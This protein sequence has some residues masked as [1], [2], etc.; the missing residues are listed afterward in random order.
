MATTRVLTN[1]Q[2]S[3]LSRET[4]SL[5]FQ[6]LL[7]SLG[8]LPCLPEVR[9][10]PPDD[11]IDWHQ[12]NS[13]SPCVLVVWSDQYP[14]EVRFRNGRRLKAVDGDVLLLQNERVFHRKP[15]TARGKKRVFVRAIVK[16]VGSN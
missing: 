11:V 3:D 14:T 4:I 6:V 9:F 16:S 13:G 15:P 10:D 2:P 7:G 12:D 1:W 8:L 5:E